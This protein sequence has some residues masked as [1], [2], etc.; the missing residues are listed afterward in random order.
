MSGIHRPAIRPARQ[1]KGTCE[2]GGE[3]ARQ[4]GQLG[5]TRLYQ[6]EELS[7][8]E[9]FVAVSIY[10]SLRHTSCCKDSSTPGTDTCL[11]LTVPS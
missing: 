1:L 8:D 2:D 3:T 9:T 7:A 4:H 11:V 10:L 5:D 6:C